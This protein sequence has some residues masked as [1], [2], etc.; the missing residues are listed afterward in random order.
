M[1][2]VP[3]YRKV[4]T[5]RHEWSIAVPCDAK[6]FEYALHNIRQA[7]VER[8]LDSETDDAYHV[9][10]DDESIVIYMDARKETT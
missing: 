4:K 1:P 6:N 2:D 3:K 9:R 10:A 8:G 5:V 7:I